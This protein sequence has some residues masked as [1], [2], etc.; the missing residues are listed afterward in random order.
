MSAATSMATHLLWYRLGSSRSW[1]SYSARWRRR[2]RRPRKPSRSAAHCWLTSAHASVRALSQTLFMSHF[3]N[4]WCLQSSLRPR[5]RQHSALHFQVPT[6]TGLIFHLRSAGELD[7]ATSAEAAAV[8][9]EDFEKAAA[10][11]AAADAAKA[12]LADLQQ[13]V[14][15]LDTTCE[16]LVR[17]WPPSHVKSLFTLEAMHVSLMSSKWDRLQEALT[18]CCHSGAS[19]TGEGSAGAHKRAGRGLRECL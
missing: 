7:E 11:S 18:C 1:P 17:S 3:I 10:L 6:R 12:R 14:R 13:A 2:P 15:A 19:C 9:A 5:L 4:P 16:R 8:E